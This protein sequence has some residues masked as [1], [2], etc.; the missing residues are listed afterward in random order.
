MSITIRELAEAQLGAFIDYPFA[1][2][3]THPHWVGELKK[4]TEHLLATA[5]PFWRHGERA[6]FMAFRDGKPAGRIAAIVNRAHNSFHSE[7]CGFFGFFDC[8]ED[9]DAAAGLFAAAEKYLRAKGMDKIRGPVNPS[10]NETCGLLIEGFD[11]P[12]M[13]M[14]P[15]NPPYYAGLIEAA[16]FAKTKDLFAY[17]MNVPDGIG[18]RFEKIVRRTLRSGDITVELVNIKNLDGAIEDLKDIYNTAWEK[19]WGF[20]P[21][22]DAELTDLGLALKPMLKPDYLFFAKVEGKVAAFVL[23]LPDFNVPLRAARGSLNLFTIIPFLY[24][25]FFKIRAGRLLTLGVKKEFRNR[26]LEILLIKMAM[27]S[28]RRM[29]WAYGEMSWTLEDNTQ[30]NTVI[31]AVGGRVYRKYRLYEKTLR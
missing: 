21:M 16:G 19:N 10:T 22:T 28:A 3:S 17:K 15:Y 30:I 26:G 24:K 18:E 1:L 8:A 14:M 6:L 13:I 5:H 29:K 27:E 12:P 11:G 2:F 4:D 23:M 7:N 31:E 9:K 20:I 25:M